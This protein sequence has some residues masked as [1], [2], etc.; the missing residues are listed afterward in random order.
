[1]L[2]WLA[3]IVVI[4]LVTGLLQP[5]LTKQ[6]RFGH[7]PGDLWFRVRG[8]SFHLPFTSTIL[9]S[10]IAWLILRAF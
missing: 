10:L 8:R 7:L 1:M 2:K 6:L 4:V 9:L 5:A 3:V